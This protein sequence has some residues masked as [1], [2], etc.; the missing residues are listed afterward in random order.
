MINSKL[1]QL[2]SGLNKEEKTLFKKWVLSP[3]HNQH[4]DVVQLFDFVTTKRKLTERVLIK[5]KVFAAIYPTK[6][7]D[8]LRLRHLMTLG[9][10]LL[11]D[12]VCFFMQKRN[13]LLQKKHLIEF[14]EER[15][16]NKF[17]EQELKKTTALQEEQLSKD[18]GYYYSYYKLQLKKF[19]FFT[20][21]DRIGTHNIPTLLETHSILMVI[22]VLANACVAANTNHIDQRNNYK[23]LFL[24][25]VLE[26][27]EEGKYKDV[28]AVQFYFNAYKCAIFDKD[29]SY[30]YALNQLLLE[31]QEKMERELILNLYHIA[32]NY[33]IRKINRESNITFFNELFALYQLGI[34]DDLLLEYGV[35]DRF[36]YKNIIA[37]GLTLK[38]V[39]WVA[40]FI[41]KQTYLVEKEHRDNYRLFAQVSLAY[42]KEEYE[43]T[44]TLLGK[45]ELDDLFLNIAIKNIQIKVYYEIGYFDLL[46]PF[47]KSCDGYLQRNA[48]MIHQYEAYRNF[49]KVTR[50]LLYVKPY[51]TKALE[52]L[53]TEV[54]ENS[55]T[56]SRDWLLKQVDKLGKK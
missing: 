38:R 52:K 16:I 3:V 13:K 41:E 25:E 30:F 17:L 55:L 12:F 10:E 53:R 28:V 15:N 33:C 27:V 35:L 32:V 21:K 20:R 26:V 46:E 40:E 4:K 5:E 22:E 45:T 56:L 50:R 14:Y 54:S 2:Y 24:K 51:D 31:G 42:T 39:D 43:R 9:V 49:I 7:Y 34:K 11:E 44:L 29:T 8:D 23:V 48:K 37:L 6:E 19:Y 36:S 18:Q 47:L 1:I